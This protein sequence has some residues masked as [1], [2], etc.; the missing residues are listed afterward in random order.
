VG[1]VRD[2]HAVEAGEIDSRCGQRARPGNEIQRLEE[3]VACAVRVGRLEL[4]WEVSPGVRDRR[5]SD[6]AGH[7]G[8]DAPILAARHALY[9]AAR[10]RIRGAAPA[11]HADAHRRGELESGRESLVKTRS[12]FPVRQPVAA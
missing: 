11:R 3:H 10:E 9:C 6:T 7:A 8:E 4:V 5:A 12:C 2:E 1:A